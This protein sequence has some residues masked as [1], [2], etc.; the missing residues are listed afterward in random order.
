MTKEDR[1]AK[2]LRFI[3]EDLIS[4]ETETDFFANLMA[5]DIG[6]GKYGI[7]KYEYLQFCKDQN[8]DFHEKESAKLFIKWCKEQIELMLISE[9]FDDKEELDIYGTPPSDCGT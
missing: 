6:L 4:D 7:R 5:D 9:D 8:I 3:I 2:S 1:A